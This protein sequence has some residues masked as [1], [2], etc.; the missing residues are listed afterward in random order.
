MASQ[1]STAV[2]AEP[3]TPK[4]AR[5]MLRVAALLDAAVAVF[6]EKGYEAATM[7]EIAA[8]AN[9]AIGSLYQFFPSKEA[10]A[11]A[12][13][14]RYGERLA[15]ALH[16]I[17]ARAAGLPMSVLADA[18][19]DLMLE[20]TGE[21]TIGIALLD[22]MSDAANR[23][24]TLRAAFRDDLAAIVRAANP[25]LPPAKAQAMAVVVQHILKS[26]PALAEAATPGGGDPIAEARSLLCLYLSGAAQTSS[27]T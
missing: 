14:A 19:V 18:L 13:L 3:R 2:A 4:R 11:D 26:V 8:G 23:R 17:A 12:L 15:D 25:A 6:A 7:T 16:A 20:L 1:K 24:T 10:L 22:T 5:G 27:S 9:A 21:R